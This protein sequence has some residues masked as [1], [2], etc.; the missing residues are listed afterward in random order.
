MAV[1]L[2]ASFMGGCQSASPQ[3]ASQTPVATA[4]AEAQATAAQSAQPQ[5]LSWDTADLSWKKDTSP[6]TL[7]AFLD[8]TW[9]TVDTW[10]KDDVSKEITKL[11]GVSFNITKAADSNQ[12]QV[13]FAADELPDIVYSSNDSIVKRLYNTDVCYPLEDLMKS[14]CPELLK[15]LTP[16]EIAVNTQDDGH[17]YAIK[18]HYLNDS[19]WSNPLSLPASGNLGLFVRQDILDQIGDPKIDSMDDLIN[20]YKTVKQKF[21]DMVELLSNFDASS[22][23]GNDA[24]FASCMGLPGMTSP[25]VTS[26]SKVTL[27]IE[28]PGYT[29]FFKYMN[30]LYSDGFILPESY[31]YNQEQS[32]Q[33][34][35]SGKV[36][37][38]IQGSYW[39]DENGNLR[40]VNPDT[41]QKWQVIGPL[42]YNGSMKYMQVDTNTGWSSTFITKKCQNPA[43]AI[44]YLEFIKSPNG[45]RLTQW[46]IEGVH[47][48]LTSDGLIQRPATFDTSK[49]TQTGVGDCEPWYWEA[50]QMFEG[51]QIESSPQYTMTTAYLKKIKPMITRMPVLTFVT[52]KA[53]TDEFNIQN[54]II[55]YMGNEYTNIILASK[56]QEVADKY[57]SLIA[58]LSKLGVAQLDTYMTDTYAK[59]NARFANV[60]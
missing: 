37:S 56:G 28:A 59:D 15:L 48:T 55:E 45:Q 16:D 60:K 46:G 1:A 8:Q 50:S 19:E 31:G 32:D 25:F 43:K 18:S 23:S 41:T 53:D 10:G 49:S 42:S 3:A 54:K 14:Y 2:V 26:D 58:N 17:I 5:Q 4:S 47:Y 20:V 27:G 24:Y 38:T 57:N 9:F 44:N 21:P 36:F 13:L 51:L 29:D 11:T 30:E 22:C 7:S 12:L 34:W 33:L 35:K 39:A 40:S 52:P 6:V